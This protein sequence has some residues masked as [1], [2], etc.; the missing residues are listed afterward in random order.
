[1]AFAGNSGKDS[2]DFELQLAP[3]IDAFTVLIAFLLVSASFLSIGILDAGVAAAGKTAKSTT[4]PP[5]N[6]SLKLLSNKSLIL[7]VSGKANRSF[8]IPGLREADQINWN[9]VELNQ[10][11]KSILGKWSS[12]KALTIEA[13]DQIKYEDVVKTMDSVRETVPVVLLGGF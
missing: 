11:L 2:Q 9:Y 4:P 13:S 6:L 7:K 5:I 12:V 3:I 8:T 10:Q 1:M